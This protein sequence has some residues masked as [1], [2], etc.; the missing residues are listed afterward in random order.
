MYQLPQIN[1]GCLRCE[2]LVK[3]RKRITFGYGNPSSSVMF[4]GEA[5]GK[6]G[7]DVT[8]IPFTHDR[9]GEYF[10]RAIRTV[11]WDKETIYTTNMVKCC[12]K[13]NRKPKADEVVNCDIYIKYEMQE[14]NPKVIVC[15]G[16]ISMKTFAP[17]V[18][19]VLES[20]DRVLKVDGRTVVIIP[21]PAWLLRNMR[22]EKIYLE[23]FKKIRR[24]VDEQV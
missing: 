24:I 20:W 2:E 16:E 15:M 8:G 1:V 22:Y 18:G 4:I 17:G 23:S 7:C 6:D 14:I 10:Q 3:S 21:H 9:S 19:K 5:P 13:D 12:P 11:G